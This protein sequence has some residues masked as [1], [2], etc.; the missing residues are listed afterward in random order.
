MK[1]LPGILKVIICP[2]FLGAC[3]FGKMGRYGRH[4]RLV[5]GVALEGV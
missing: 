3:L 5:V 4:F 1:S 2:R